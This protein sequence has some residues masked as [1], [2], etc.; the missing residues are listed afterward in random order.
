M[1]GSSHGCDDSSAADSSAEPLRRS[2]DGSRRSHRLA[3]VP[4]IGRHIIDAAMPVLTVVP[5]DK[6]IHPGVYRVQFPEAP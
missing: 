4:L 5:V 1:A 3:V 6:A 2:A